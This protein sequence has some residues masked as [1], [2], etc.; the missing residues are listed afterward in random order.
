MMKPMLRTMGYTLAATLML[1]TAALAG[2]A[3]VKK[4]EVNA[5]GEGSYTF[6]VTIKSEDTGWDNYADRYEVLSPEGKI[7]GTRELAHPHE[8]EQPFTRSLRNVEI[9]SDIDT[10]T[11]RAHFNTADYDGETISVDL[12]R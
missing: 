5:S 1:T 11:V 12:P 3:D 8:N 2:K 10:V 7:L 6:D 9:P 4:V